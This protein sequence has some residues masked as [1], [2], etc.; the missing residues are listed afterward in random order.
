MSVTLFLILRIIII[1]ILYII[2]RND[3]HFFTN[4]LTTKFNA[5]FEKE[6]TITTITISITCTENVERERVC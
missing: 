3:K 6:N 4:L 2:F 1:N 5:A